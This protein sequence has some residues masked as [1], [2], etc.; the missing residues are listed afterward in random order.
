MTGISDIKTAIEGLGVSHKEYRDTND[1]RLE[2]IEAGDSALAKELDEKLTRIDADVTKY[3]GMKEALEREHKFLTERV[4]EL[5]SRGGAPGVQSKVEALDAE[6]SELF[7]KAIRSAFSNNEYNTELKQHEGKLREAKSVT[8]GTASAGGYAVPEIIARD[9]EKHERKLSP[10]RDL[11]KVVP[12]GSSD[13]KELLDIGGVAAGWVGESGSRTETATSALREIVPTQGELYA[14]PQASEWS[15]D[16]VFFSVADWLAD[17]VGEK[18]AEVEGQAVISGDGTTKPTGMTNTAPV[19]T[20]DHASP[21]RAAAAYEFIA[22][23]ASP[24]AITA[25]SLIDL[26]YALNSKYRSGSTFA[27]NSVTAGAIRK[28]KDTTNQYL[29]A[30]GLANG[31]PASLLGFPTATWEDMADVGANALPVAFGNFKR[32][33]LLVDRVGMRM[34]LDNVTTPGFIKFYTRRREGG[35]PLNNDAIK[36]LKTT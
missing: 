23:A 28:L 5:E 30:P 24:D 16:D 8:I 31:E 33:Y 27:M 15:L 25:D 22:S 4:E 3:A 34:T 26:V 32:G 21:L 9:I 18:F 1:K 12:I 2:A 11:V 20:D 36:F 19:A 35:I 13:Y 29:W 6:H 10:V 17:S 7:E 14:Y